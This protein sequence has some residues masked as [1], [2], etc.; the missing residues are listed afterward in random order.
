M[1]LGILVTIQRLH[2][3]LIY[4]S[5]WA[6]VGAGAGCLQVNSDNLSLTF[7]YRMPS[8]AQNDCL[9]CRPS[10][11]TEEL[12]NQQCSATVFV[13]ICDQIVLIGIDCVWLLEMF[14][15]YLC[16]PVGNGHNFSVGVGQASFLVDPRY[17]NERI[18]NPGFQLHSDIGI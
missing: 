11:K 1:R 15:M 6:V 12:R 9:V 18:Q 4:L 5:M 3:S 8:T 13:V 17:L 7:E 2:Y 10:Q 16:I 14:C